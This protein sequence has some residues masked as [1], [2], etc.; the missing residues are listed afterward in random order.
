MVAKIVSLTRTKTVNVPKNARSEFYSAP[1]IST[2][3]RR[4]SRIIS[5]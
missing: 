1:A 4:P 3:S 5:S 2:Y